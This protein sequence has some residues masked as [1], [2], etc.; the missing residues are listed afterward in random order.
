MPST[1]SQT[2]TLHPR[3]PLDGCCHRKSTARIRA[4][5]G[6]R[7]RRCGSCGTTSPRSARRS[8]GG[9]SCAAQRTHATRYPM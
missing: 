7:P 8:W 6:W 4:W 2:L 1:A 9:Q 3:V 5:T